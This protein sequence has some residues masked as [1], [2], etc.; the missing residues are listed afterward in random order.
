MVNTFL[1][2]KY[3]FLFYYNETLINE[4]RLIL[5]YFLL[6]SV[7]FAF[8]DANQQLTL[9]LNFIMKRTNTP[10]LS[11]KHV[12]PF[13]FTEQLSM[14]DIMIQLKT[15]KYP[16]ATINHASPLS[17]YLGHIIF[18]AYLVHHPTLLY[19]IPRSVIDFIV[20]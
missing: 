13:S 5:I 6:L 2:I 9:Q 12:S 19:C 3:F 18:H 7:S 11:R 10:R 14:H 8:Q 1:P 15:E 16:A 4:I 17:P 20:A